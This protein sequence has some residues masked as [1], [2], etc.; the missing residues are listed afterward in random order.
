MSQKTKN[1]TDDIY[2]RIYTS[3]GKNVIRFCLLLFAFSTGLF[4]FDYF[5]FQEECTKMKLEMED[6]NSGFESPPS[7][8]NNK[9]E[10]ENNTSWIFKKPLTFKCNFAQLFAFIYSSL[11]TSAITILVIEIFLL[12]DFA[13]ELTK[14]IENVLNSSKVTKFIKAF[15]NNRSIYQQQIIQQI[16]DAKAGN[17]IKLLGLI[18]E[19]SI[20]KEVNTA[21]LES[22]VENGVK[23]KI[24][25][26]DPESSLTNCI[27]K[28]HKNLQEIKRTLD[29]DFNFFKILK[30]NLRDKFNFA[31]KF[32][33]K[34]TKDIY[35]PTCY[36]SSKDERSEKDFK[37]FVWVYFFS[38]SG[39]EFRAFEI[40]DTQFFKD[41]ENHFE[42]HADREPIEIS[43]AKPEEIYVDTNPLSDIQE[44][45]LA[46]VEVAAQY[47]A[48]QNLT[49]FNYLTV[50][51]M[52]HRDF[53]VQELAQ[54]VHKSEQAVRKSFD[55]MMENPATTTKKIRARIQ[56][57]RSSQRVTM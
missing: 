44:Q 38:K 41:A 4:L 31:E 22:K 46:S 10:I 29:A 3:F 37:A 20:L 12:Q 36:F 34:V 23:F 53:S 54:E 1:N 13:G 11:T 32:E 17:E 15:Y 40:L 25:V 47:S 8:T 49:A 2:Y 5:V 27:E 19:V 33:L 52:K 48:A 43:S 56:R 24:L 7:E 39:I 14:I 35:S 21:I 45:Q 30:R 42:V 28:T 18:E 26:L 9:V 6:V 55:S 16:K 51:Y 50:D 57:R